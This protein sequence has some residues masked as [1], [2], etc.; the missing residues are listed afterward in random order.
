M[1][2]DQF[3]ESSP[4]DLKGDREERGDPGLP[5]EKVGALH[6]SSNYAKPKAEDVNCWSSTEPE[7]KTLPRMLV[8][9]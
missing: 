3:L 4:A 6:R 2:K 5:Q 1:L 8:L 9:D 7:M